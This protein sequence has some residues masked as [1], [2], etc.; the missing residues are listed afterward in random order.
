MKTSPNNRF[1]FSDDGQ[2]CT[3]GIYLYEKTG[4]DE[5]YGMNL[6]SPIKAVAKSKEEAIAWVCE[7]DKPAKEVENAAKTS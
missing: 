5:R 7:A 1:W 3:D 6:Y 2:R 4:Y